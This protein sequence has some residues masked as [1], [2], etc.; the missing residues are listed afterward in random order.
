MSM[1]KGLFGSGDIG[2]AITQGPMTYS[3]MKPMEMMGAIDANDMRNASKISA[4]VG[5]LAAGGVAA[6]G[7]FG[8][9]AASGG[10]AAGGGANAGGAGYGLPPQIGEY[11]ATG[12]GMTAPTI[13]PILGTALK[14]YGT[15]LAANRFF[16]DPMPA[17][18]KKMPDSG[19][20]SSK[21]NNKP[22]GR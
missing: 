18:T 6:G 20:Q 15:G 17:Q 21:Q 7:G 9:T 2:N 14:A 4:L 1:L 13:N 22:R 5:G 11:G 8:G 16:G 19:V 3:I 10:G 12:G